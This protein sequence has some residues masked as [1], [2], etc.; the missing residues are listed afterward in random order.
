MTTPPQLDPAF[1]KLSK[2]AQRALM[3][4][5]IFTAKDLARHTRAEVAAL[6]GIGPSAFPVLESALKAAGLKFK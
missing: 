3:G 2:P 6:H 1:A 4:A 5:G